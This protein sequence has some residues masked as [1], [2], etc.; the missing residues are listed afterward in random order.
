MP[1]A[2]LTAK[3]ELRAMWAAAGLRDCDEQ[4]IADEIQIPR[5]RLREGL[6]GGQ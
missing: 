1:R 4:A 3:K 2:I 5:S 6:R